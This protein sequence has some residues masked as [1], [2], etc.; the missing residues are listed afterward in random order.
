[1]MQQTYR[2]AD[3]LMF[4]ANTRPRASYKGCTRNIKHKSYKIL[5]CIGLKNRK[6]MLVES[7]TQNHRKLKWLAYLLVCFLN[8][9][10]FMFVAHLIGQVLYTDIFVV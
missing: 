9:V 4:I 7:Q 5:K 3:M 10:S 1:M 2:H 6:M 8:V